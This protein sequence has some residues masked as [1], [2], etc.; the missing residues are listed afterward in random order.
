[1]PRGLK[2][3]IG[4]VAAQLV[5][6]TASTAVEVS[7]QVLAKLIEQFDADVGSLRHNDH[8]IR[9]S[10]LVAEWPA[11]PNRPDPD[12]L[13]VVHFASADPIFAYCAH[14]KEP[15]A[16]QLDPASDAYRAYR[17]R[18]A[19]SRRVASPSVAVAP[20]VSR[21]VTTGVLGFIKFDGKGWT[22]RHMNTLGAIAPMFAG[23]Q[24]RIATEEKLR[25]LAEHDDLTGLH[26]RRALVAHLSE[27]LSAGSPGPVAVLYL[28]LDR[29]KPINE[30]FGHSA[31]DRYLR[32]FAERLQ[33]RMGD[34]GVIG[35]HGGDEFI[36]I[37][38]QPMSSCCHGR[39]GHWP[40]SC[41]TTSSDTTHAGLGLVAESP[42]R[43][44]RPDLDPL[45]II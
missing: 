35:R 5:D 13:E 18:I 29:L 3:V 38:D 27:R 17:G 42:P 39:D 26:N 16:M 20:L 28:D 34:L 33:T 25:Y 4:S 9:A 8:N 43:Y 31:G 37:P 7:Q 2:S 45:A 24:I 10:Q 23:V 36:V 15:I 11:R 1:V 12:P 32:L 14:G 41:S 6:A 19:I 40:P 44:E 22:P 30:Y 21:G